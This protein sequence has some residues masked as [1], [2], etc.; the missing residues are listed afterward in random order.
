MRSMQK[1]LRRSGR[2]AKKWWESLF[3]V[4]FTTTDEQSASGGTK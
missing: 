2:K 1:L 4:L 3:N